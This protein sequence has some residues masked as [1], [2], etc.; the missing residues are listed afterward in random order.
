[1]N[2]IEVPALLTPEIIDIMASNPDLF[3][4][5]LNLENNELTEKNLKDSSLYCPNISSLGLA[6]SNVNIYVKSNQS[7]EDAYDEKEIGTETKNTENACP[8]IKAYM[9]EVDLLKEQLAKISEQI[10]EI[11]ELLQERR[12]KLFFK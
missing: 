12:H 4:T 5:V 10:N 6:F 11:K 2:K 9:E 3:K 7:S 1:M 8:R